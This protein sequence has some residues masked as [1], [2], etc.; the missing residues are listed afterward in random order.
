MCRIDGQEL[1]RIEGKNAL[2]YAE[3][4]FWAIIFNGCL[5][6][7]GTHADGSTAA[8]RTLAWFTSHTRHAPRAPLDTFGQR[9]YTW[10]RNMA[11]NLGT[12]TRLTSDAYPFLAISHCCAEERALY[13]Y[14]D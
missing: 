7:L 8:R 11:E 5:W 3:W 10:T 14:D 12:T 4:I 9:A 13:L 6:P 1:L 2:L